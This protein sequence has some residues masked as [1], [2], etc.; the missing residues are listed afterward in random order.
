MT[1]VSIARAVER[2]TDPS[3]RSKEALRLRQG[4]AGAHLHA[5]MAILFIGDSHPVVLQ[6]ASP[7]CSPA[8]ID[9][10]YESNDIGICQVGK[11]G[12][13]REQRL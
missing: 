4:F 6:K 8:M 9:C 5:S 2:V 1:P 13:Y 3:F 12:I 10:S 7:E 11:S